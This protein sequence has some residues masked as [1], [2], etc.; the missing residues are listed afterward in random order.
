MKTKLNARSLAMKRV[1]SRNPLRRKRASHRLRSLWRNAVF[2]R[3]RSEAA[4]GRMQSP[5]IR[6]RISNALT[7]LWRNRNRRYRMSLLMQRRWRNPRYRRLCIEAMQ[8]KWRNAT[9]RRRMSLA[10]KRRWRDPRHRQKLVRALTRAWRDPVR[11][12]HRGRISRRN[13]GPSLGAFTLQSALGAGW[14]LECWTAAGPI[15]VAHPGMRLAIEVDDIG[16]R[17]PKQQRR[18]RQKEQQLKHLG[19]TVFRVSEAGC[20]ALGL[21]GGTK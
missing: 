5:A 8:G 12:A 2:R 14:L 17:R 18:D 6:R 3:R 7:H 19:W 1:W 4:R 21:S 15:D 20:Q 9:T 11:R 13:L 10:F 16:H